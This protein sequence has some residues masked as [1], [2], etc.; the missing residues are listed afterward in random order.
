MA[1]RAGSE[2][3]LISGILRDGSA[4]GKSRA[5]HRTSDLL[6]GDLCGRLLGFLRSGNYALL[7]AD[8]NYEDRGVGAKRGS[9]CWG[10]RLVKPNHS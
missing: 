4:N 8:P 1:T 2:G 7:D 9:H 10:S 6:S 5:C 3:I